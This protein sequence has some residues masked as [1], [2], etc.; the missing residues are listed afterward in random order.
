MK[1][2]YNVVIVIPFYNE[3]LYIGKTLACLS[4][5]KVSPK[6]T[7]HVV[8]VDNN[9][10]DHTA[11]IIR[12]FCRQAG[13][14]YSLIHEAKQGTVYSRTRGLLY[15]SKISKDIIMSTDADT[16]FLPTFIASTL[17]DMN[18]HHSDVLSGKRIASK[19]VRLWKMIV[20]PNIVNIYRKIGNLEYTIFG[21]YF[22][23]S[24]FAIR[25][26]FFKKIALFNPPEHELFMGE[27]ILLSRRC[28]YMGASFSQSSTR[29]TLHPRRDI[30]NQ[31]IRLANFVGNDV[32]SHMSKHS[33]NEL[34]FKSLS[35]KQE[36]AI[37]RDLLNFETGRFIWMLEDAFLFWEKTG[38]IYPVALE[39]AQ[40]SADFI[41]LP[42]S[43]LKSA[44]IELNQNNA[45]VALCSEYFTRAKK[46]IASYLYENKS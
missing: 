31:E 40:K 27:D 15:A 41:G 20:A 30:V 37:Q 39:T 44:S 9:S 46:R 45:Y 29:V 35:P 4:A 16:T 13:I 11:R 22:F 7:W 6:T 23:G 2:T 19:N 10:T 25:A 21:P 5:Q 32:Y 34:R 38:N 28:Y 17:N 12:A 26:D 33:E 36:L 42:F 14:F 43:I 24:Y 18:T 8:F 1:S 3:E